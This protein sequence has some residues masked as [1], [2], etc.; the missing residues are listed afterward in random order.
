MG[1]RQEGGFDTLEGWSMKEISQ[2]ATCSQYYIHLA[3]S[4]LLQSS[5]RSKF[6][7]NISSLLH[8]T[9]DAK[10]SSISRSPP[11]LDPRVRRHSLGHN[12][13]PLSSR[14]RPFAHYSCFEIP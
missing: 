6:P 14:F 12:S 2:G 9:T 4:L 11:I 13:S 5:Q 7:S 10:S 8:R 3:Y 1:I